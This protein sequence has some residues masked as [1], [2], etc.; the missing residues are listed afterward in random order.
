MIR[1]GASIEGKGADAI[2]AAASYGHYS[3][4]QLLLNSGL[5]DIERFS[6]QMVPAVEAACF[7]G[8]IDVAR[9]FLET[10]HS[11]GSSSNRS[12]AVHAF[13][14]AMDGGRESIVRLARQYEPFLDEE[15]PWGKEPMGY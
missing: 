11:K 6:R 8:H 1:S 13:D 2:Q 15:K 9:L 7:R 10:Y 12:C 5:Y 4:V 3:T 14:A